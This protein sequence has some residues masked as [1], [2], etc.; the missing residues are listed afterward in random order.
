MHG[1]MNVKCP[2]LLSYFKE[3]R[4]YLQIFEKCP[5][6]H[7]NASIEK[8]LVPFGGIDKHIYRRTHGHDEANCSVSYFSVKYRLGD[9]AFGAC[10]PE[11]A[12]FF[13]PA[14]HISRFVRG[15]D[16]HSV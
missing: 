11:L 16:V 3:T 10:F 8:R 4:I 14:V 1:H 5:K 2:L 7:E 9:V 13:F 12:G 15:P 6:F